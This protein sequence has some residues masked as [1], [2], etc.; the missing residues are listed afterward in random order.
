YPDT[1]FSSP[2]ASRSLIPRAPNLSVLDSDWSL[3]RMLGTRELLPL[4][5]R[6]KHAMQS[7]PPTCPAVK[8]QLPE[9]LTPTQPSPAGA[10]SAVN[11]TAPLSNQGPRDTHRPT[12]P[13][14]ALS[15]L[16]PLIPSIPHPTLNPKGWGP[17]VMG[18]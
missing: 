14:P 1:P 15:T 12:R 8:P 3:S 11:D 6:S 16:G 10:I 17:A 18:C 2:D 9:P 7:M 4:P 13:K 5:P